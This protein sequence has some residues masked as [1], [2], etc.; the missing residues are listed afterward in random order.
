MPEITGLLI[1]AEDSA[2]IQRVSLDP[3]ELKVW[4]QIIGGDLQAIS[5]PD[6]PCLFTVNQGAPLEGLPFNRRATVLLSALHQPWAGSDYLVG[7]AVITGHPD[8]HSRPVDV[9]ATLTR[10]LLHARLF[11]VEVHLDGQRGWATNAMVFADWVSAATFVIDLG[12]RWT[13]V[14]AT[15][16][17][18]ADP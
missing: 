15:R 5:V 6:P 10:L 7:N 9:P 16:I 3:A 18:V 4:R 8:G 11:K 13:D 12:Q 1:P 2:P 17:A 14:T